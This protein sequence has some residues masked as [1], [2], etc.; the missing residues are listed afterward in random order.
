MLLIGTRSLRFF[1]WRLS[2]GHSRPLEWEKH[3]WS[4]NQGTDTTHEIALSRFSWFRADFLDNRIPQSLLSFDAERHPASGGPAFTQMHLI[5][6]RGV[7]STASRPITSIT[8]P[9]IP[10]ISTVSREIGFGLWGLRVEKTPRSGRVAITPGVDLKDIAF[11][12]VHPV[13]NNDL[14]TLFQTEQGV[15]VPLIDNQFPADRRF[16]PLLGGLVRIGN[17]TSDYRL[18]ASRLFPVLAS[19]FGI[20]ISVSFSLLQRLNASRKSSGKR[21]GWPVNRTQIMFNSAS[22]HSSSSDFSFRDCRSLGK[23]VNQLRKVRFRLPSKYP[24]MYSIYRHSAGFAVF[25]PGFD[26][27]EM[28]LP[29]HELTVRKADFSQQIFTRKLEEVIII[30]VIDACPYR[31]Q[32]T[33]HADSLYGRK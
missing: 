3:I 13:E 16:A 31:L 29:V 10:V 6:R 28:E 5:S 1:H 27:R 18:S 21:V 22:V 15:P 24:G 2:S 32:K 14:A 12:K 17:R 23:P 11:G 25:T 4:G 9:S 33:G 20:S 8:V 30:A 19:S 7:P 26:D